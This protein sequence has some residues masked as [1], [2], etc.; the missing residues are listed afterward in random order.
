MSDAPACGPE[1]PAVD[2]L[3]DYCKPLLPPGREYKYATADGFFHHPGQCRQVETP[4]RTY[5]GEQQPQGYNPR[6]DFDPRARTGL[7][8]LDEVYEPDG[9]PFPQDAPGYRR[10]RPNWVEAVVVIVRGETH[11]EVTPQHADHD[12]AHD[13]E[14]GYDC[15]AGEWETAYVVR[16]ATPDEAAGAL[17]D[18]ATD[19]YDG[20]L[21]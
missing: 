17:L 10:L 21:K 16:P 8:M 13:M 20:P 3:C 19:R 7:T 14:W 6:R 1:E 15:D 18:E 2:I 11:E 4:W 12:S 9:H 5:W